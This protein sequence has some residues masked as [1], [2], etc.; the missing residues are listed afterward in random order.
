VF[1][2]AASTAQIVPAPPAPFGSIA[3]A[4]DS[5]RGA[6]TYRPGPPALLAQ[7]LL[8]QGKRLCLTRRRRP[9]AHHNNR[10]TLRMT[11]RAGC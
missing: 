7:S 9:V 10:T 11:V 4:A 2:G 5:L 6:M 8:T 1:V 3:G